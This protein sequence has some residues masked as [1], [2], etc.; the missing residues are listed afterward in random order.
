MSDGDREYVKANHKKMALDTISSRLNRHPDSITRFIE[1]LGLDAAMPREKQSEASP[2]AVPLVEQLKMRP[3]WDKWNNQFFPD[4]MERFVARYVE[5]MNQFK[6]DVEATEDLLVIQLITNELQL[7]RV[8]IDQKRNME[9][10]IAMG[11]HVDR[12]NQKIFADVDL[13]IEEQ[14]LLDR[15]NVEY[16]TAKAN[17]KTL[18]D[19]QKIYQDRMDKALVA[20]KATRQQRDKTIE[21]KGKDFVSLIKWLM[22]EENRLN[23]G[24]EMGLRKLAMETEYANLTKPHKFDN[25][26]QDF[27]V[28]N[29]DVVLANAAG[30]AESEEA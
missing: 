13:S 3:D 25:G 29:S 28:F 12:L 16:E 14:N 17:N 22:E 19:R 11:R 15:F 5:L 18:T 21:N 27:P 1:S 4:E 6:F 23:A 8:L 24:Q 26:E 20:L 30:E 9:V 7:D 2:K 10:E